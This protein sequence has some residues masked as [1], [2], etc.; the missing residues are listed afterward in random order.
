MS[1][2]I[3]F[4][5]F[6]LAS[7]PTLAS[8]PLLIN[9]LMKIQ[10]ELCKGFEPTVTYLAGSS[11]PSKTRQVHCIA[12]QGLLTF[13]C[14]DCVN[15]SL[16]QIIENATA[17]TM[18]PSLARSS[19]T[20]DFIFDSFS[21]MLLLSK[22]LRFFLDLSANSSNWVSSIQ[23]RYWDLFFQRFIRLP[24]QFWTFNWHNKQQSQVQSDRCKIPTDGVPISYS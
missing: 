24:N 21:S 6:V 12:Q 3:F 9:N 18:G 19:F 5:N 7:K 20:K 17:S 13:K 22:F 15:G 14:R 4:L 2:N 11:M 23:L 1:K 8:C 16:K 10:I